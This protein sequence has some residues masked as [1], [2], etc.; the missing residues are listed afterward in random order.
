MQEDKT[1]A[2]KMSYHIEIR[3]DFDRNNS[4]RVSCVGWRTHHSPPQPL[5]N[6]QILSLSLSPHSSCLLSC[7]SPQF[8]LLCDRLLAMAFHA[9][10]CGLQSVIIIAIASCCC[11]MGISSGYQLAWMMIW[12]LIYPTSMLLVISSRAFQR[13][14]ATTTTSSSRIIMMI[15]QYDT[16]LLQRTMEKSPKTQKK[17]LISTKIELVNKVQ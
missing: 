1:I 2:S 8:V 13:K 15:R 5:I 10:A 16:L 14:S 17:Y 4:V 6:Q 11:I 3:I 7:P 12:L 9:I